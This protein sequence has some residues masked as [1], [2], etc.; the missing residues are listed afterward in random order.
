MSFAKKMQNTATRLLSKYDESNGRIKLLRKGIPVWDE[1]AGEML[2]G[3]T[4]TVDLV[5]VTVPFSAGLV[6]GTTIQSGDVQAIVTA[7]EA[8]KADDKLLIDGAEW[9]IVGQPLI[10]YTG[11][12]ICYKIHARK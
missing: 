7:T 2:P 4:E 10:Q 8:P 3:L 5:G 11:L 12:A 9:S 1:D 6:D